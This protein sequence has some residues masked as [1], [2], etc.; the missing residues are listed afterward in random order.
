[1]GPGGAHFVTGPGK[2]RILLWACWAACW[3]GPR[4]GHFL[5]GVLGYMLLGVFGALGFLTLLRSQR[6][7]QHN[8]YTLVCSSEIAALQN[9]KQTI[10]CSALLR[11]Q[12]CKRQ[13]NYIIIYLHIWF[14]LLI[15]FCFIF[16]SLHFW[17]RNI[18]QS[19][20]IVSLFAYLR[21]HNC[22]SHCKY[23]FVARDI[24]T[25]HKSHKEI[26]CFRTSEIATLHKY[27]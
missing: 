6:C 24:A 13:C 17:D 18:A 4:G 12:H 25:L 7:K 19:A 26:N 8:N 10:N 11:S 5:M 23:V 1:M 2:G 16:V 22:K 27:K 15:I 21:S 9:T 20:I 3:Y 14:I